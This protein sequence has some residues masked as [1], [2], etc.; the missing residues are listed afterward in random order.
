MAARVLNSAVCLLR[1]AVTDTSSLDAEFCLKILNSCWGTRLIY[2]GH[3]AVN[4][5]V[6]GES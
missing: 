5:K 4:P 3:R 1:L 2:P 6:P